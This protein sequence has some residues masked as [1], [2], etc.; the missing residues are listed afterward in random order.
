MINFKTEM[1]IYDKFI[2]NKEIENYYD[3]VESDT[4]PNTGGNGYKFRYIGVILILLS[5]GIVV[6][7]WNKKNKK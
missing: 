7:V 3:T 6:I 5:V 2:D 1:S 4:I